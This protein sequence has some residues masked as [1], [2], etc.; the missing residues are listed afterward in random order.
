L[1]AGNTRDAIPILREVVEA[2][3]DKVK[4]VRQLAKALTLAG[5]D[6]IALLSWREV[7]WAEPED[8]HALK[9]IIHLLDRLGRPN[10]AV[11]DL[12]LAAKARPDD[13][14][15]RRR[16]VRLTS[17]DP[18]TRPPLPFHLTRRHRIRPISEVLREVQTP[19]E[20]RSDDN[21]FHVLDPGGEL[22]ARHPI[23]ELDGCEPSTPISYRTA[24][25]LVASI[26]NAALVGKGVVLTEAGDIIQELLPRSSPDK[27]GVI[28][29]DGAVRFDRQWFKDR[30][31]PVVRFDEPAFLMT[32]PTE[33]AFGDWIIN[34]GPRLALAR[35]AALDCRIVIRNDPRHRT[36]DMLEAL[37]VARDRILFHWPD[38][39]SVFP[40]LYVPS[41][42]NGDKA[43]PMA[44][45]FGV[46][47]DWPMRPAPRQTR[48]L[49][50]T[51]ESARSR[52]MVN[53]PAVRE[54][55]TR[56]GFEVVDP[57][58]L[59][60]DETRQMFSAAVCL[61]GPYGSAFH[62]LVFCA[63]RVHNLVLLPPFGPLH[64][65]EVMVWH[66]EHRQKFS[67]IRGEPM[68]EAPDD[69]R[70]TAPLDRVE[71]ALEAVLPAL[72]AMMA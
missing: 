68:T 31:L 32:G 45:L 26:R 56:R 17:L 46:Y 33:T 64:L 57:G 49:Y 53:E 9:W 62:N 63:R 22:V 4:W 38:R 6:E 23:V 42:P 58:T 52:P 8:R 54:M 69:P 1:K 41:W 44:G 71:R 36:R 19:D 15:V 39:V 27:Y 11:A 30:A 72:G 10:D 2:R 20:L 61:A 60:H 37:G 47:E 43:A 5:E 12:E 67:Y 3:P 16:L 14:G 25:K 35:A 21:V 59:S 24:A 70:W 34:F 66:A 29:R 50:L 65:T 28:K 7:L 18:R 55:F 13:A 40:K 51:R 48:K